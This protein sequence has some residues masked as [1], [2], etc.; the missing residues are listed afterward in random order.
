MPFYLL[1][2]ITLLL[3]LVSSFSSGKKAERTL[4]FEKE[5]NFAQVL[6]AVIYRFER[7]ME[8]NINSGRGNSLLPTTE[9]VSPKT[10]LLHQCVFYT[11]P[12]L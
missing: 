8:K 10:K 7:K 9:K 6:Y 11:Q 2:A 5:D 4:H 12:W 3:H 1:L